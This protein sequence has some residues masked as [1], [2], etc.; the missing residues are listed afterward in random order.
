LFAIYSYSVDG[1]ILK[2]SSCK[3]MNKE[4]GGKLNGGKLSCNIWNQAKGQK[5]LLV[6]GEACK[7]KKKKENFLIK[8]TRT[9]FFMI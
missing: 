7:W 5:C 3:S 8:N 4:C 1:Q 6:Y 9:N 2:G